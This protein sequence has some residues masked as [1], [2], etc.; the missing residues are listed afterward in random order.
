MQGICNTFG[1]F[2]VRESTFNVLPHTNDAYTQQTRDIAVTCLRVHNLIL[3][4]LGYIPGVSL[5][6]GFVR[7]GTGL[8]MCSISQFADEKLISGRLRQEIFDTGFFQ[9][10]RGCLEV[11]PLWTCSCSL[12]AFTVFGRSIPVAQSGLAILDASVTI[13]NVMQ[14]MEDKQM[15]KTGEYGEH[16]CSDCEEYVHHKPYPDI[17]YPFPLSILYLV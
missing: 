5:V 17:Q 9:I 16:D 8:L 7:M 12:K 11:S 4:I 1:L 13:L 3:N 14:V 15:R 10:A 6:S 2:S